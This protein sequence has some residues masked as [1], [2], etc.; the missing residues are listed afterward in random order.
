MRHARIDFVLI[1]VAVAILV[2]G[3]REPSALMNFASAHATAACK[4]LLPDVSP[5]ARVFV[6]AALFVGFGDDCGDGKASSFG[7]HRD[8]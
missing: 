7:I 6:A 3:Q 5:S 2:W 8:E 4:V 1:T